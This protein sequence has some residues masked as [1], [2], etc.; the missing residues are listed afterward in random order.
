MDNTVLINGKPATSIPIQDRGLNYGDGLFETV[1]VHQGTLLC[2]P[3]HQ[4]RLLAGCK[5]LNIPPPD[6]GL[7][8]KEANSL[9]CNNDKAV[10]KIIITRGQGGRG[11]AIAE[12]MSPTRIVSLHLWPDYPAT[13]F[14][15]G[16]NVRVCRFRYGH[17]PLL[18]GIKHLNRLEQVMA[19][20]EWQDAGIHEG[21][22]MD[23]SDNVIEG[24]MSNMFMVKHETL[25]TPS[26]TQCGIKGTIRQ[27]ILEYAAAN[28]IKTKE[29][30]LSLQDIQTADEV[31]LC[32]SIIGIWPI[33]RLEDKTFNPGS[34]TQT[35]HS[36][37]IND[38]YICPL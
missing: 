16:V 21:L 38:H 10:I 25:Y 29:T 12:D 14:E 36:S 22:V 7:L 8:E 13:L 9:A 3:Q 31:F 27:L 34:M 33:S 28:D 23:I 37:L 30:D 2:W 17:Q 6:I 1:A 24:T 15:S 32:N 4:Q 26:L 18:A 35:L 5:T 11:Y 19:R 20:A